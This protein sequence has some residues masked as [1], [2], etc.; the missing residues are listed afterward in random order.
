M[1]NRSVRGKYS[2]TALPGPTGW[3]LLLLCSSST[4]NS[5]L[6]AQHN[7][8]HLVVCPPKRNEFPS[9]STNEKNHNLDIIREMRGGPP[10]RLN[11]CGA[12]PSVAW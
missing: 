11:V 2:S 1:I 5:S 8:K 9:P 12:F 7:K 6:L 4:T 10:V 3:L